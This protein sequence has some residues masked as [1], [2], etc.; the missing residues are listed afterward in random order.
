[1]PIKRIPFATSVSTLPYMITRAQAFGIQFRVMG[2]EI[3]SHNEDRDVC[4]AD[5]RTI[6]LRV[7]SYALSEL[8]TPN[9]DF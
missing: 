5:G 9:S 2:L 3:R 4:V 1:M 7:P 8:V 6:D